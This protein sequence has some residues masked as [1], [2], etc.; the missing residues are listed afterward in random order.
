MSDRYDG[1]PRPLRVG[2][3]A[4]VSSR[5]Q[6]A[7]DKVSLPDQERQGREFADAIGGEVVAVYTVAGHTREYIFYNAAAAD[8]EAYQDLLDDV[9][10]G[11]LDVLWVLDE[12]R[13]GRHVAL[14][15]QLI[16]LVE[17]HGG[18]VFVHTSP[19]QLG[20]KTVSAMYLSMIKGVRATEELEKLRYK[21]QSGMRGRVEKRGMIPNRAPF[22]YQPVRADGSG[23]ATRYEFDEAQAAALD[24]ATA[25]FLAGVAYA[26]IARR[27][28][29]SP[30]RPSAG[31]MW[32]YA[33]VRRMLNNDVYAGFPHW[34]RYRY[35]A[36]E[37][38]PHFPAR[39]DTATFAAIVRERQRRDRGSYIRQGA[40]PYT[41]VAMC[42]RCGRP[43]TR[44]RTY[45]A[46]GPHFYLRC[47]TH[48]QMSVGAGSTGRSCHWNNIPEH[49]V[50]AA[51]TVRLAELRQP[52]ALDAV[53]A[54][55]EGSADDERLRSEL[56]AAQALAADL[57]A[58]RHRLALAY[59]AGKMDLTV[60]AAADDELRVQHE[61][62]ELQAAGLA[63]AVAALPDLAQRRAE[64]EALAVDFAAMAALTEPAEV[65]R[66]L[67]SAGVVVWIENGA[68]VS[69]EI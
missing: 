25:L 29:A 14:I 44:Y 3:W 63:R 50:T 61:A 12:D 31:G 47:S 8:M 60:Y 19:H 9:L 40:G 10:A 27:L 34:G 1:A 2:V 42:R 69:V 43:M 41:G 36:S 62:A 53:L 4:A 56:D 65:A 52:G 26:E 24:F 35:Q 48:T 55:R 67:Q 22:G 6:A 66:S 39:W 64:L 16:A 38:S 68:V 18:E 32:Y 45:R 28:N 30:H 11:R 46:G 33:V 7:D 21:I 15:A 49:H 59:G 54:R 5:K 57:A 58:Q 17:T 23:E 20:H 13:L 51:V 37:P